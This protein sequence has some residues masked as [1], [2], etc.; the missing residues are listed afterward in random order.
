MFPLLLSL[1]SLLLHFAERASWAGDC[2]GSG[3]CTVDLVSIVSCCILWKEPVGQETALTVACVS[4]N[5]IMSEYQR[6]E[7]L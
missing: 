2:T 4:L 3:L 5:I 1:H 7:Q 6:L